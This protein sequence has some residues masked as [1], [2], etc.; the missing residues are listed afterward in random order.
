M[1]VMTSIASKT[2]KQLEKHFF[3]LC[4][5]PD[6][7]NWTN[8]KIIAIEPSDKQFCEHILTAAGYLVK[9]ALL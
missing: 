3:F 7:D 2:R 1:S 4:T 6:L 8:M 5:I 9:T